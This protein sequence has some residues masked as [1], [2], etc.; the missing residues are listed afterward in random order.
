MSN[1]TLKKIAFNMHEGALLRLWAQETRSEEDEDLLDVTFDVLDL[2][3][4]N[5]EADSLGE[6]SALA[7][8]DNITSTDAESGGAVSG[9]G[10]VA[11]LE[12]VVLLD[13]MEVITTDDDGVLHLVGDNHTPIKS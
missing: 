10:L 7:D 12:S 2:L 3:T 6:G 9:Y 4:N 11:L 5:V 1:S 13:V 8:G